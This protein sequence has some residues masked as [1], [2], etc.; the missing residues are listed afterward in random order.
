MN[1]GLIFDFDGLIVDTES[2]ALESWLEIYREY[3]C[4]LPMSSWVL[5]I[6]G[7]GLEFDPCRYLEEQIGR[8]L[9]Y[10][11]LR[12]RRGQLK[13]DMVA[14]QPLLPGVLDYIT[15]AR[16]LG[17]KLAVASN[18]NHEWVEGHL[19][20]LDAIAH[21]DAIVCADDVT[22]LK[23]DPEI[24]RTALAALQLQPEEAIAL[25]DSPNGL[26]AAKRAGLFG[27]AIPSAIT[28]RL[29]FDHADLR[30]TSMAEMPLEHLLA[31]VSDLR[32]APHV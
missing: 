15:T 16:R 22:H 10:E 11:A 5:G 20:R 3:D 9:D 26:L 28:G 24:Y 31:L 4:D 29:P 17:L 21:F 8:P 12:T 25:E 6:G 14:L 23:P 2:A 19:A 32:Q 13:A 30:L 27:V 7:S 1:K 18:S